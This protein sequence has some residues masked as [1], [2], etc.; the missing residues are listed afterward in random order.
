MNTRILKFGGASVATLSHIEN[1]AQIIYDR[2]ANGD[3]LVVVVSAM[4]EMTDSFIALAEAIHPDPPS[5]EKDMLVS[6]GERVSMSL[7]AMAL[8]RKG[9][10]AISLTGSQTGVITTSDQGDARIL[11]VRP[12]RVKQHLAEGKV[13]IVAGFQ[14]VSREKEVTTLGRGGSDTSAVALGVA[15]GAECVEFYKDVD[16]IYSENPK[17]NPR[18]KIFT[19]VSYEKLQSIVATSDHAVLHPRAIALAER[20]HLMLKV[21]SYHPKRWEKE[22]GTLIQSEKGALREPAFECT[23]V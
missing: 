18:A 19:T 1:V 13:V 4:G 6:V 9:V 21:L 7:L 2:H 20:N 23:E 12:H 3:P 16:G 15:L 11:D 8:L 10:D 22:P 17:R 14:G 5:R